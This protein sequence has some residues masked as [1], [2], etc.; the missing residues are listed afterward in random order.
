MSK[1]SQHLS[2]ACLCGGDTLLIGAPGFYPQNAS[3]GAGALYA[4]RGGRLVSR[5]CL[6]QKTVSLVLLGSHPSWG[7]KIG[8]GEG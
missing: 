4:A 5:V 8:A 6:A 7:T 2:K 1:T 3:S